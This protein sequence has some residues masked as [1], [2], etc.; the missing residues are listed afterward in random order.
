MRT[1]HSKF[2]YQNRS[3]IQN[4]INKGTLDAYDFV[5]C[6]DTK[7]F[8]MITGDMSLLAINSKVYRYLDVESAEKSLNENTDTYEGQLISIL[9]S[10]GTYEAYIVNKNSKGVFYTTPLNA[11]SGSIDYDTLQHKPITNL[12]GEVGSPIIIDEQEDGIYKVNGNYKISEGLETIFS[13]VNNNLFIVSHEENVV[14]IKKISAD[15]IVDYVAS[16]DSVSASVI[17]TDDWLK[18]QGYITGAEVDK[19][20]EALNFITKA[21]VAEYV[22]SIISQ[23]IDQM[24][25]EKIDER[26]TTT[27]DSE[28]ANM[29]NN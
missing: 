13:S 6:K 27:S 4:E 10:K 25:D 15:E 12:N 21:E 26:F 8:I 11:Y 16:N 24:I 20:I 9:S 5:I 29:F 2:A 1:N 3:E 18:E 17:L 23:T 14:K 7:E 22:Q 28:I 19:K